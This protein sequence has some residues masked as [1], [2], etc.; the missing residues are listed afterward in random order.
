MPFCAPILGKLTCTSEWCNSTLP[1]H[2][3][4]QRRRYTPNNTSVGRGRGALSSGTRGRVQSVFHSL[5]TGMLISKTEGNCPA[6]AY[7]GHIKSFRGLAPCSSCCECSRRSLA[8]G[9]DWGSGFEATRTWRRGGAEI[10]RLCLS[11]F[12]LPATTPK[13]YL[14]LLARFIGQ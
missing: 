4:Y 5:L 1:Q 12:H 10:N 2:Y 9:W 7:S 14:H 8:S 11:R 6:V 13:R 3:R